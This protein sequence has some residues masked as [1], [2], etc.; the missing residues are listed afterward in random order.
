VDT[1]KLGLFETDKTL[2]LMEKAGI[3]AEF[4][5]DGL[6]KDRGLYIGVKL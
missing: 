2:E 4:L 5:K 6:M 3:Q 1:H